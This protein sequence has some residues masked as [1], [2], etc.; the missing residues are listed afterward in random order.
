MS[1]EINSSTLRR[2]NL[3]AGVFHLAQMLVVLALANDFSLPIVARYM[4]GPPGS[5][6]AEPITLLNT[7]V[8]RFP[9]VTTNTRHCLNPHQTWMC[10]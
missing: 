1:K 7:P 8:A 3:I 6:F 2:Y 10:H 4:A 9:S 5:T